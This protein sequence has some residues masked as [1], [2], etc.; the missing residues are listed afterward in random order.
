MPAAA[1]QPNMGVIMEKL[2]N[3]RCDVG[4]IKTILN[5]HV[6]AQ[7][8][9]ETD[10]LTYRATA[11]QLMADIQFDV[12]DHESRLKAL[13]KI[14]NRLAITDAILR[15]LAIVLMGSLITLVIGVI[16]HQVILTFP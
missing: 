13:E 10:S 16:T 8:Q 5:R 11:K 12:T 14:V 1:T 6:D 7:V 9:F 2:E 15:W 4:E 3:V